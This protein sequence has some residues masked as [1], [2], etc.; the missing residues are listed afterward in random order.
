MKRA[1]VGVSMKLA[2]I[3]IVGPSLVG[4]RITTQRVEHNEYPR[5]IS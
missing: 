1:N 3:V 4:V 5:I 2:S